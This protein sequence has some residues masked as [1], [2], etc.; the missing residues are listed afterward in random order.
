MTFVIERTTPIKS[1]PRKIE[2]LI[3][4]PTIEFLIT[5]HLYISPA[6]LMDRVPI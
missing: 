3:T 4:P 1:Q 2:A 5:L 6:Q